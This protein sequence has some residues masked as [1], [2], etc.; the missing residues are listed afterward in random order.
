LRKNSL[1][2]VAQKGS[3]WLPKEAFFLG[4]PSR[5]AT[6]R[7]KPGTRPEGVG[8]S[9]ARFQQPVNQLVALTII[10][11]PKSDIDLS[12]EYGFFLKVDELTKKTYFLY[13]PP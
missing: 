4:R 2:Q 13:F 7:Q 11:K 3:V 9:G 6:R 10:T 12:Q 5:P 1:L 8:L